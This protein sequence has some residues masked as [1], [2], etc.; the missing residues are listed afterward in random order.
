M[1]GCLESI[2]R[3]CTMH[4]FS[5]FAP[6]RIPFPTLKL[7]GLSVNFL[8]LHVDFKWSNYATV[9]KYYYLGPFLK[10]FPIIPSSVTV[11]VIVL[12]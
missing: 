3:L 1:L 6:L 12:L 8:S 10:K 9:C 7:K 4:L 5:I 2:I 11:G